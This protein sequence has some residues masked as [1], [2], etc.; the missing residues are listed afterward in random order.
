MFRLILAVVLLWALSTSGLTAGDVAR[1]VAAWAADH[2]EVSVP[3]ARQ[4]RTRQFSQ[5]EQEPVVELGP[6]SIRATP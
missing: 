6:F 4:D 1:A 2:V 3:V 5:P